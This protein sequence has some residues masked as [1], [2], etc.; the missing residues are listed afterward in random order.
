MHLITFIW[1]LG[2]P[3]GGLSGKALQSIPAR[4]GRA[5]EGHA[6]QVLS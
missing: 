4:A 6:G 5:W 3:Y 1:L 2:V